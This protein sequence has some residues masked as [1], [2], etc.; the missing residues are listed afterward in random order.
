VRRHAATIVV[1]L[2]L[3]GTAVAFAETER[4]KLAPTAIEE[5]FV[6]PA[7]SPTCRCG[8]ARAEIRLRLHRADTATVRIVDSNGKTIRTLLADKRLPAGR[9][10][11][12]WDG[13][14]DAGDRAPDGFYHVDVHLDRPARTFELPRRIALDTVA[15]STHIRSYTRNAPLSQNV[16]V[17][18]RVN[19]PA[20]AVLYVNGRKEV[21]PTLT[22]L[23]RAQLQWR[24]PAP[25]RYRLQLAAVNLA[26]NLGP[27][28]PAVVVTVSS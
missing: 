1:L 27:R 9:T 24:A 26:G 21:G 2:L 5:S 18:Y 14:D 4:L 15:P 7:F 11:L 10:R 25:G 13:R 20:H 3:I 6:Q 19:E 16:R 12:D 28:T 17:F 8:Q 23:R 22:K